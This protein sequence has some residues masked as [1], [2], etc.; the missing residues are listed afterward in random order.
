MDDDTHGGPFRCTA[1]LAAT[2]ARRPDG[3]APAGIVRV[4][5]S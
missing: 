1:D 4:C 2:V 5:A 3:A